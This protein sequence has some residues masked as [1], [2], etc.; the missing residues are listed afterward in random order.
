MFVI[1]EKS[2]SGGTCPPLMNS[3][4]IFGDV[5]KKV[6]KTSSGNIVTTYCSKRADFHKIFQK[7]W[8]LRRGNGYLASHPGPINI[9]L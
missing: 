9:H 4:K 3:F 1:F 6:S 5:F 8:V 2:Y 7:V